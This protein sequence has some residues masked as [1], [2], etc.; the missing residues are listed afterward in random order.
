MFIQFKNVLGA[1]GD[2]NAAALAPIPIDLNVPD[3]F[4]LVFS[5][6]LA[7]LDSLISLMP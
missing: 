2:T 3:F 4:G 6:W 7:H 5:R 1:K